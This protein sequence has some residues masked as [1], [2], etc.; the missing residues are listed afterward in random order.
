MTEDARLKRSRGSRAPNLLDNL[1]QLSFVVQAALDRVAAKHDLSLVQLRLLGILRTRQPAMLELAAFLNLDKSSVTGLVSRAEHR[2][3]VERM[4]TP[5]DR[6]AVH[7]TL[8]AAGRELAQRFVKQIE[9]ELSGLVEN[10]SAFDRQRLGKIASR[11]IGDD[12]QRHQT[13]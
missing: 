13:G 6:R 4:T 3:L 9:K 5:A 11:I 12:T 10:L 7:V 8:T 1:V 2:G